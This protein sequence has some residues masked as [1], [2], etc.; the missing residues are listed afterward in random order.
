MGVRGF[1]AGYFSGNAG[2]GIA[3]FVITD[4]S[5]SGADMA[6]VTFDGDISHE[7]SRIRGEISVKVPAGVTIIQGFTA[8]AQGLE[9][10]VPV[11]FPEA[12]EREPF[13]A[14]K[15]PMGDVNVRLVK[16]RDLQ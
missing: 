3:M 13:M 1:Y 16:V 8:P 2:N 7:G 4:N 6:G 9:Y 5:I 11:D 15:T 10:K 14:L 12:F